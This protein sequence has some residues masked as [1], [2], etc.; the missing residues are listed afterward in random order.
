MPKTGGRADRID[1]IQRLVAEERY[2]VRLHTVR[3]MIEEGF[4]ERQLREAL[5]GPIRVLE[6]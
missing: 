5:G 4:D 6:E 2:R 1:Q 3:H